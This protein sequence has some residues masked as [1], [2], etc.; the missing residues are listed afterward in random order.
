MHI[1]ILP[2]T[3]ASGHIYSCQQLAKA[4]MSTYLS[5][6][7]MVV[8]LVSR[9]CA[10]SS[11]VRCL[12]AT[13]STRSNALC[14]KKTISKHDNKRDMTL[15]VRQKLKLNVLIMVLHFNLL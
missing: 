11:I 3:D 4:S 2:R 6:Q 7:S 13:C 14:G 15:Y 12:P 9:D 1:I 8:E 5:M 10:E